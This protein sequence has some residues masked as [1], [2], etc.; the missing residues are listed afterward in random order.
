MRSA[1]ARLFSLPALTFLANFGVGKGI[2]FLG[3]I[4]LGLTLAPQTY[5]LVEYALAIAGFTAIFVTCGVPQATMQL[6]VM[7]QGRRVTDLLAL[8]ASVAGGAAAVLGLVLAVS[9]FPPQWALA[10]SVLG[11]TV[12]QQCASAYA[13]AYGLRNLTCWADHLHMVII[14]LVT[15]ALSLAARPVAVDS[16][17]YA[18]AVA[19]LAGL[20][21]ALVLLWRSIG[22]SMGARLRE[23]SRLG[24]PMLLSSLC[25]GWVV[26]SGRIL[27]ERFLSKDDL[28]T[29]AFTFRVA[30]LL[31]LMHAVIVTA[32]AARLYKMPTRRFDRVASLMVL[33]LG[34]GSLLFVFLE[35][36]KLIS[37]FAA[38][39]GFGLPGNSIVLAERPE[40]ALVALQVFFW[41]S[42]ALLEM[43]LSRAR[44]AGAMVLRTLA[45][46]AVVIIF[47]LVAF[48]F[49]RLNLGNM[50]LILVAQQGLLCLAMHEV[51]IRR[52]VPLRKTA[53]ATGAG[54]VAI[55][56]A[57]VFVMGHV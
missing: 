24:G 11:L 53:I 4:W 8:V 12:C 6:V 27:I 22:P 9:G 40:R 29:Y 49:G 26:A 14:V 33:A 35:P 51:L 46:L 50:M 54:A 43:R 31:L 38:N 5:A 30:G 57:A 42:G 48:Q 16:L 19:A 23:A 25:Y 1:L 55:G 28:Y 41:G 56:M 52:R 45:I 20:L 21:A 15:A 47:V 7:R 13:R 36:E 32:F 39:A 18:L 3:P 17:K 10:G 37:V 34:A 2:A 44:R